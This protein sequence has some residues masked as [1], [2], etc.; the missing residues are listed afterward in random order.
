MPSMR[1]GQAPATAIHRADYQAPAWW[2]DSGTHLLDLDPAK[3]RVLN[4]MRVRRNPDV[5]AQPLRLQGEELELSRVLV[6]GPCILRIVR[7]GEE[8]CELAFSG[9]PSLI[10]RHNCSPS[11]FASGIQ[12]IQMVIGFVEMLEIRV[13]VH[14]SEQ[15]LR[16]VRQVVEPVLED[17]GMV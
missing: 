13:V 1:D 4:K 16:S 11:E 3:T 15:H 8:S 2:I 6:G 12:Q 9:N 17:S 14:Q 7:V 10:Y 5:A